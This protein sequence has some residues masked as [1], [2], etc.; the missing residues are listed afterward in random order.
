MST[1]KNTLAEWKKKERELSGINKKKKCMKHGKTVMKKLNAK[2]DSN[3]KEISDSI[4][5]N[6][7]DSDSIDKNTSDSDSTDKELSDS[8]DKELSD[9]TDKELSDSTDKEL[10]DRN[11]TDSNIKKLYDI[12]HQSLGNSDNSI[13]YVHEHI[14]SESVGTILRLFFYLATPNTMEE[15]KKDKKRVKR[16][17]KLAEYIEEHEF[18]DKYDMTFINDHIYADGKKLTKQFKKDL[19]KSKKANKAKRNKK[20]DSDS[21]S[22]SE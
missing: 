19:K 11:Q 4:N 2:I 1:F 6:T 20:T 5:K 16:L 15:F 21:A 8:T 17:R 9:S 13:S 3:D 14:S 18:V 12:M 22:E 10:F 7:F